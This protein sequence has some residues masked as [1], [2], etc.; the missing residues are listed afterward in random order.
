[1][2][3]DCIFCKIIRGEISCNKILENNTVFAF[4]DN[5]PAT[6]GHTLVI[7]KEHFNTILDLPED[8]LCEIIKSTQ[9]ITKAVLKA[10]NHKAFNLIVNTGKDAEQLVDHVHFHIIPR[11]DGDKISYS[12]PPT[13]YKEGQKEEV[14]HK[15]INELKNSL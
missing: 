13:K 1:M 6:I 4:L 10:T 7:P 3:D 15:I 11:Y 5:N 14:L 9:K 8:L 2:S 12:T